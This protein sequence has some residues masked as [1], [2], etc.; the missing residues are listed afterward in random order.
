MTPINE[1]AYVPAP[2][3][4]AGGDAAAPRNAMALAAGLSLTAAAIHLR[5]APE[6]F[7]Q[8]WGYG[9]FFVVA[10][11][12]ELGYLALLA[13]RPSGWVLQLGI[14]M[15]LGTV[16]M[17]LV[18]RTGGIPLGPEQGTVEQ[19]DGFG[20][21]AT[22]SE[23]AL[24]LVL[25]GMLTGRARSRTFTAL[26]LTGGALWVAAFAGALTPAP[27]A[28][29]PDATHSHAPS[30]VSYKYGEGPTPQISQEIRNQTRPWG[31][32]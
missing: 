25:C 18:T 13:A 3:R 11:L 12:A 14:W 22:L 21:V 4:V 28:V 7:G 30:N 1:I 10:A 23:A 16:V 6:S 27:G 31:D 15:S 17:Y 29:S 9:A 20:V 8:W 32:G 26:A 2:A 24:V 5:V 19:L